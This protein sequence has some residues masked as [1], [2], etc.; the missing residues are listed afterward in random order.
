M[1]SALQGLCVWI[2]Y[3]ESLTYITLQIMSLYTDT[4]TKLR[5]HPLSVDLLR[6]FTPFFASAFTLGPLGRTTVIYFK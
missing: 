3:K 4:L 6:A 1:E 5:N 2:E